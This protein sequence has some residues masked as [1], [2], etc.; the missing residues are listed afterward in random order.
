MRDDQG[1]QRL[2]VSLPTLPRSHRTIS[3]PT[4]RTL[5]DARDASHSPP[6]QRRDEHDLVTIL[7][8]VRALA[9]E[10]P[11]CVVDEDE[12]AWATVWG[13]SGITTGQGTRA[14]DVHGIP[15]DEQLGAFLEEVRA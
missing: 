7:E 10:F 15:V 9:F 14:R 4:W 2:L 5:R 12:D 13:Q 3:P 6:V 11:I 8:L 1:R